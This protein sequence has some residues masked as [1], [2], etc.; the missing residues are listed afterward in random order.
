MRYLFLVSLLTLVL[1]AQPAQQPAVKAIR[2]LPD[3][4]LAYP[5]L[6]TLKNSTGSGFYVNTNTGMYL[7]TAKHVLFD[8][9]TGILTI[10]LSNCCRIRRICPTPRPTYSRSI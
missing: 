2:A 7:V 3:D 8:P 5:V 9:V 10:R 4:N 6:I 1:F